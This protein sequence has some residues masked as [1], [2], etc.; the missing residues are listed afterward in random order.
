MVLKATRLRNVS[1][2]GSVAGKPVTTQVGSSTRVNRLLTE[3]ADNKQLVQT[4]NA[5]H[6][7][8][9]S[10][11]R[12]VSSIPF[13][14]GVYFKDQAFTVGSEVSLEHRLGVPCRYMILNVRDGAGLIYRT[15]SNETSTGTLV[16]RTAS[17]C[18]ADVY[19]YPEV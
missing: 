19:I 17:T 14:R 5:A 3:G 2:R 1:I 4:I 18:R 7:G 9:A 15:A 8:L 11:E 10:V 12:M 13:A 6:D 16:L